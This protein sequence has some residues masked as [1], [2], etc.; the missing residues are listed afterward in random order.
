MS[1][2]RKSAALSG[3]SL[4]VL[5]ALILAA[6]ASAQPVQL[7][8]VTV[9]DQSDKNA[10]NHAPPVST[11]PSTSLQDTPQA[12][13]VVSGETMRRQATS[14]LGEARNVPASPSPS[15]RAHLFGGRRFKIRGFDARTMSIL[16]GCA[17]SPP[18]PATVSL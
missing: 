18:I 16:M 8:P 10:L 12:V 2:S 15:A 5:T 13:T 11:M 7:G 4:S 17:T 3:A 14:T 6:P 1:Y 9:Q